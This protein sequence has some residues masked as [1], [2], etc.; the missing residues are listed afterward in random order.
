MILD[1]L[2]PG[3]SH[4]APQHPH[5]EYGVVNL[6]DYRDEVRHEVERQQQVGNERPE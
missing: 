5:N 3:A 6:T 1:E 4:D 2:W